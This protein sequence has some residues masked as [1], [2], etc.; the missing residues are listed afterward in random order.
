MKPTITS[1]NGHAI[2]DTTNYLAA[3]P[4]GVFFPQGES[5]STEVLRS[6][7][8][9][10]ISATKHVSK[11]MTINIYPRG[12]FTTQVNQ[13]N[14]WFDTYD[15]NL[16]RLVITDEN[17][18][19]WYV[20]AKV[21]K[22]PHVNVDYVSITLR[23]PDPVWR[24]VTP[25]TSNWAITASGQ[26]KQVVTVGNR[27]VF[28]VLTITPT[29]Q[30]TGI[31]GFRYHQFIA[32]RNPQTTVQL[33]DEPFDIFA[34]GFNS[35]AQVNNTAISNQVNNVGGITAVTLSIPVDTSVG[36]GLPTT[37]GMCYVDTEQI[38][39][40]GIAAGTMTVAAGG[41][42]YG[43]TVAATHADNAVMAQSRVRADGV[44]FAVLVNGMFIDR[45]LSGW[46]TANSK[47]WTVMDYD[48]G[49][50]L[51][52]SGAIT[53][54]QAVTTVAFQNTAANKVALLTLAQKQTFTLAIGSELF[55]PMAVDPVAM[56]VT[57]TNADM[58]AGYGTT[59][60]AHA[61]GD[62]VYWVQY[63]FQ[64]AWGYFGMTWVGNDT[65][66]PVINLSSSTNTSWV[67]DTIFGSASGVRAASWKPTPGTNTAT[68]GISGYSYCGS[69]LGFADPFTVMGMAIAAYFNSAWTGRLGTVIWQ[70]YNAAGFTTA[71]I[72]DAVYR[73]GV[74]ADWP[75]LTALQKSVDGVNWVTVFN[76]AAPAGAASW[77]AGAAHAGVALGATYPYLRMITN[78]A[79]YSNVANDYAAI[80]VSSATMVRSSSTILQSVYTGGV[81]T[82]T[83][84]LICT[85]QNQG[86]GD[87]LTFTF[88]LSINDSVIL[89]C[90]NKKVTYAAASPTDGSKRP[91]LL[92]AL[93]LSSPRNYWLTIE[94]LTANGGVAN[95]DTL[96][97]T[98]Q[99]TVGVT[100]AIS[101]EDRLA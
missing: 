75:A 69:H 84:N 45:W 18:V 92:G 32:W 33:K 90:K 17:S 63:V 85:I 94:P 14:G 8:S 25:G 24:T 3:F 98:D 88:N 56:T 40:T 49:I 44:D 66:K 30:K 68:K 100:V 54:V 81:K 95:G 28:P 70:L 55:T 35:A 13:L 78:G 23:V 74:L 82:D 1:W 80:E 20:N 71:T 77:T 62:P 4:D 59:K 97:Y 12:V 47:I 58:R 31:T 11:S 26:T 60:A 87:Y 46:N 72:V 6:D 51:T 91:Y 52:L 86:T 64:A 96:I 53:N 2:N 99:N 34:A 57:T 93:V 76:E 61:D 19:Q 79:V 38:Y 101:Y 42:G 10:V 73:V 36:G 22:Q 83:Y 5:Q 16:H 89:D 29:S 9:P 27:S 41:R 37:G 21:E 65:K 39:Y 15:R 67:W 48:P 43:G 50:A 7:S